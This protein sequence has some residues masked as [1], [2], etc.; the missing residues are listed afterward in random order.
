VEAGQ[1]RE[2]GVAATVIDENQLVAALRAKR[3]QRLAEA[4]VGRLDHL[5][6]VEAGDDD[7]KHGGRR[8]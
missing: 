1:Q 2:G 6:L 8:G 4:P 7:R 5:L 3:R